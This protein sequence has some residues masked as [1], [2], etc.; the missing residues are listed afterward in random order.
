MSSNIKSQLYE[1]GGGG[2]EPAALHLG[3][4]SLKMLPTKRSEGKE[5]PEE[6]ACRKRLGRQGG[7]GSPGSQSHCQSMG[8]K[9]RLEGLLELD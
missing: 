4:V 5:G 1:T 7:G 8:E 3:C 2:T 6:C 9:D